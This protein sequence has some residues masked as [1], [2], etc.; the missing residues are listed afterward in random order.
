M[1]TTVHKQISP[2]KKYVFPKNLHIIRY[3]GKILII[4]VDIGNWLVLEN[5][6]QLNFFH[7]LEKNPLNKALELFEGKHEDSIETITQIEARQFE[8]QIVSY[9]KSK[10]VQIYLT[11]DCNM[12]C[13]HCYMFAGNKKNDELTCDEIISFLKKLKQIGISE[14]IFSGGEVC[15]REDFSE[16]V[17]KTFSLGFEITVFTNGVLW[18]N[19][20]IE[21]LSSKITRIQISIDGYCEEENAKIRGKGNFQKALSTVHKFL[22]HNVKTTIIVTPLFDDSL[23]DKINAYVEFATN[24]KEKYKEKEFNIEFTSTIINGR[25][26]RITKENSEKYANVIFNIKQ[27]INGFATSPSF[28]ARHKNFKI[29]DNCA[30]G[31]INISSTGDIFACSRITEIPSFANLRTD[32]FKSIV[33][34]SNFA[35]QISNINNLQPCK[36]CE[37]KYICG[38]GCRLEHFKEFFQS[39][40]YENLRISPCVCTKET[41]DFYYQ[42]MIDTNRALFQ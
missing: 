10:K 32:S 41:K 27:K 22:E 33:E 42:L 26:L 30:F 21:E 12:R 29:F 4:A 35:K 7:L 24:L 31:N 37:L 6:K 1:K 8:R 16:I 17:N 19:K 28:L 5:E 11:N 20:M 36:N 25:N 14:V 23:E 13:P 40:N 15:T 9:S 34:I 3:N 2:D 39:I 38:G 18:T